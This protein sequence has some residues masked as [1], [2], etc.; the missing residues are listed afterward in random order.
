MILIILSLY[1]YYGFY[2]LHYSIGDLFTAEA[3]Y[4][5]TQ[6]VFTLSWFWNHCNLFD[7]L[8]LWLTYHLLALCWYLALI[9]YA[10]VTD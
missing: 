1:L 8:M 3:F 4:Y 6:N 7:L 5:L 10:L 2:Y 9:I